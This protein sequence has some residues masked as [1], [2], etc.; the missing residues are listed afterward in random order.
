[1]KKVLLRG[2]ILSKSGYGVHSR[3]IFKYLMKKQGIDLKVQILPWGITPWYLNSDDLNGLVG[4]IIQRSNI[5]PED[6]FDVSLQVQLPNEWDPEA[7]KYNVG[8]TAGVETDGANPMWASTHCEKMDMV[9][10]P[11]EHSKNSLLKYSSTKTPVNVVPESFYEELLYS[12]EQL[13]DLDLDFSTDFNFLTVG[14]LTGLSPETDR[15]NLFYQI[16]WFVEHFKN[17]ENVGLVVKTNRGRETTIDRKGTAMMLKKLLNEIGHTGT[18]KV[19]LLHG[20]MSRK[21]LTSLYR[22]PKIKA[23]VSATRGEGFGLPLLEASVAELPVIATNWSSHKEFL[24]LGKWLPVKYDLVPV[25]ETKVDNNIFIKNSKWAFVKEEDFKSKL[26]NF[27]NK[28]QKPK[29]W[30]QDLSKKLI[31]KY[32]QS[33]IEDKYQEVLGEVLG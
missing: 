15:K 4:E 1:M 10:V 29:E 30:A 7:A 26:E 2:P 8:I 33:S 18:P 27:Y 3:Q 11:S 28:P 22:H 19:Y 32:S 14:V 6:Q 24:D 23:F 9:I 20:A 16:K 25:H 13:P 31:E 12:K 21:E 5:T 17:N